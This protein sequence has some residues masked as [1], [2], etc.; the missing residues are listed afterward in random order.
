L[1]LAFSP[2]ATSLTCRSNKDYSFSPCPF[3]EQ[4]RAIFEEACK[5]RVLGSIDFSLFN[6]QAKILGEESVRRR[7]NCLYLILSK[8]S[9]EGEKLKGAGAIV[10]LIVFIIFLAATLS[11][12]DIFPG[13]AIYGLLGVQESDY[14]VLGIGVT[15]LVEAVFNGVVYGVIAW[16]IFTFSSRFVKTKTKTT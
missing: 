2:F 9:Q 12:P 7:Q 13:K 1:H 4:R 16:L 15:L 3:N 11:F 6:Q 10:F 5:V 8:S 14:P